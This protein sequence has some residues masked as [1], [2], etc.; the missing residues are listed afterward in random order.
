MGVERLC[1]AAMASL[2]FGPKNSKCDSVACS[3]HMVNPSGRSQPTQFSDRWFN[4]VHGTMTGL[5]TMYTSGI[6]LQRHR[7]AA[8]LALIW[9]GLGTDLSI[10]KE[11][12][13]TS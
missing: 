2:S 7:L 5:V 13:S 4:V 10:A 9:I 3:F 8:L 12:S 6:F 11:A 1:R